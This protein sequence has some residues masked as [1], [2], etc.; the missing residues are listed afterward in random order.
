VAD[1]SLRFTYLAKGRYW[2]FRHPATGDIAMPHAR[3]VATEDQPR[4]SRFVEKYRE[5]LARVERAEQ[6]PAPLDRRSFRWL[7]REYGK[8][9]EYRSLADS[10]QQDYQRT[11]DLLEA[12]LGDEP[13][14]LVTRAM[15][16]AVRDG[17]ARHTRKAHKIKQMVS[18]LYSWADENE[19]VPEGYNPA[20]RIKRLRRKGGEREYVVWSQHEIELFLREAPAHVRTPAMIALYTGQRAQDVATMRWRQWQGDLIRVR[21]GKTGAML[22]IACHRRLRAHLTELRKE[23]GTPGDTICLTVRGRAFNANNLGSAIHRAIRGIPGMPRERSL[24]GLRYAAGAAMEEAGCSVAEIE[25][26]LGH[27][28]FRMALKYASQRLRARMAIDKLEAAPEPARPPEPSSRSRQPSE[29]GA[30]AAN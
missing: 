21:Q 7:I 23:R 11:L 30:R 22:D 9:H 19:L 20:A 26:V 8:S 4:Q 18:R 14:A 27:R 25:A 28:T 24:H 6:A 13:F 5:L 15:I 10:T 29:S 12:E 3:G 1:A 16:K 17:H 2:R